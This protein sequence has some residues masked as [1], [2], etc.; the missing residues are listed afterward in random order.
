MNS[1]T[2]FDLWTVPL[3]TSGAGEPEAGT[4]QPFLR[5]RAIETYPAFSP[6]GRWLSYASNRSGSFEVYVRAFPDN[7][8]EAPVSKNGGRS[9]HWTARGHELLYGTDDQ[10]I[11]ITRYRVQNGVFQADPPKPFTDLRLADEGVLPNFDVAPDGNRVV[12]LLPASGGEPQ[13]P[14]HVTFLLNFFD[15]VRRIS[16]RP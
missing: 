14:N 15:E 4:P 12:A 11:M 9:S 10:R 13:A 16:R 7:G 5:T 6:D 3:Q 1:A 2:H 8:T